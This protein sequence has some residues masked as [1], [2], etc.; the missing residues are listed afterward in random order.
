MILISVFVFSVHAAGDN[1]T[2][3]LIK[4]VGNY[5]YKTVTEP[6]VG[7]VG[8]EWTV[9]GL[10]RSELD[11]PD[12]YFEKYY[13][14]AEKYVKEHDGILHERKYTE[15]S[16]VVIAL[17]AIGK[18]PQNIAGYNL[19]VPLADYKKTIR[20]GINGAIWALIALDSGNYEIP[21]SSSAEIRAT[22]EMYISYIIE[23]QTSDGGW[24]L[25]GDSADADVTGMA[26]QA[27]SRYR[28]VEKVKTAIEKALLCM[29]EKQNE[30]GGF[31]SVEAENSE[32]CSQMLSALSTL[33][34]SVND[35]RFVKN[36]KTVL[37]ALLTFFIR[38]KG[39]EHTHG[40]G[41]NQ[42]ATEQCF[43]ALVALKRAN[44]EK[45]GLYCMSDELTDGKALL[46]AENRNS[47]V[48][49]LPIIHKGK[50]F[51]DIKN[52]KNKAKTEAL[53]ARGII[54]GKTEDTF[55]P[56][57]TMTRAEFAT[58]I[59]RGL[60]L[61]ILGNDIFEDVTEDDWFYPYVSTAYRYGI[62]NGVS[63]NL[64]DPYGT[65]THEQ[66]AVI[67]ARA[68]RLCGHN[69]D[70]AEIEMK[71]SLICFFD[72]SEAS[73]WARE[74]LAFCLL[75]GII[76]CDS[77]EILPKE[78]VTRTEIAGMLYNMLEVSGLL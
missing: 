36:G 68:A 34:I 38:E 25:Y 28:S 65:L 55:D 72:Y 18:D 1:E 47:D 45:N 48:R 37:D 24:S 42:M 3:E 16:R 70:V 78:Y 20:Q 35:E 60:G 64:F 15:Y 49:I 2:H 17:T 32:S 10:A 4:S 43:Y 29:S 74:A 59:A 30:N 58:V 19:L 63:E 23:R 44:E 51:E 9:L 73:E 27:L 77:S 6:V 40:G 56:D 57:G 69:T 76:D 52:D 71:E 12:E 21:D 33:G 8:G 46:L 39:F 14:T 41:V 50:T 61:L 7:S 62:I 53:A 13:N 54:N 26:L 5:L 22:R 66:A 31:L 11:I 75:N 67:L